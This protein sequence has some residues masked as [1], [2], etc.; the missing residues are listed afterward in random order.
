[1]LVRHLIPSSW[2]FS[3]EQNC[4]WLFF[5]M[6]REER[7]RALQTRLDKLFIVQSN[8]VKTA[9]VQMLLLSVSFSL[10]GCRLVPETY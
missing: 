9:H 10:C 8:M 1:M 3:E 7:P 4:E 5:S 6:C 2:F